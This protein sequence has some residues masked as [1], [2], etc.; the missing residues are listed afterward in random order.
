MVKRTPILNTLRRNFGPR[1]AFVLTLRT[2]DA[3]QGSMVQGQSGLW[4]PLAPTPEQSSPER[5]TP[6]CTEQRG[7]EMRARKQHEYVT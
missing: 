7:K 6:A 3:V 2:G 5:C 4:T 1:A